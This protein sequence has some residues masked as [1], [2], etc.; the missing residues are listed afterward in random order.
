MISSIFYSLR[1][2]VFEFEFYAFNAYIKISLLKI[3]YLFL[4]IM[5]LSWIKLNAL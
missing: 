2:F 5:S 4:L 3:E 1:R